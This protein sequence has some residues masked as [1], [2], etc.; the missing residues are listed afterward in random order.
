MAD[1]CS[2]QL[3]AWCD[4]T[5]Q[6]LGCSK[7]TAYIYCTSIPDLTY[8]LVALTQDFF[9]VEYVHMQ[10]L[11]CFVIFMYSKG[12]IAVGVIAATW[13]H[14]LFTTGCKLHSTLPSHT[15]WGWPGDIKTPQ[16]HPKYIDRVNEGLILHHIIKTTSELNSPTINTPKMVYHSRV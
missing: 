4:T 14:Q 10:R 6:L 8:I 11:E 7:K 2:I 13:R 5:S 12:F 3:K 15:N 9:S 16:V 1:K